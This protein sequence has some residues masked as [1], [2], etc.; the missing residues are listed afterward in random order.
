MI[1]TLTI[2][3]SLPAK[4]VEGLIGGYYFGDRIVSCRVDLQANHLVIRFTPS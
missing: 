4:Y 3:L 2:D 1:L